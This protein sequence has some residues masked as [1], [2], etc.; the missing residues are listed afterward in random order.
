MVENAVLQLLL[1]FAQI[2]SLRG[3]G[4]DV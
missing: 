1:E 3:I 2:S 4:F